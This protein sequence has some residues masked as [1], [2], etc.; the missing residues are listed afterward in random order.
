MGMQNLAPHGFESLT[1]QPIASH[2]TDYA[3]P[4]PQLLYKHVYRGNSHEVCCI[5]EGFEN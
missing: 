4:D 2:Y 3:V 1:F 5:Q